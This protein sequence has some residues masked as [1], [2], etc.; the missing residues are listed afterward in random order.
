M[1]KRILLVDDEHGLRET[2]RILLAEDS[3][4]VVEANNGAEALELFRKGQFDLVMTDYQIPFIRGDELALAVR[5]L[6]PT[7]PILMITGYQEY[8]GECNPVDAVLRK[9]FGRTRLRQTMARL[10][11]PPA[12]DPGATPPNTELRPETE[13]DRSPLPSFHGRS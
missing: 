8:P 11:N 9:P 2:V 5:R 10:L 13:E 4:T 3:Y 6:A 7:Q 12:V 1:G